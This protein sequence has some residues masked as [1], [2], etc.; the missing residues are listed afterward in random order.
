MWFCPAAHLKR[1]QFVVDS[2]VLAD[3]VFTACVDKV[4]REAIISYWS[5]CHGGSC[6]ARDVAAHSQSM[7]YQI[8]SRWCHAAQSSVSPHFVAVKI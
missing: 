1:K 4:S 5:W 3:H 6:T 2:L 7:V 8:R